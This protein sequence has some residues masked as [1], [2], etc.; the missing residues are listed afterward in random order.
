M[1][2]FNDFRIFVV[3]VCSWGALIALWI[4]GDAVL[5]FSQPK[6]PNWGGLAVAAI[7]ALLAIAWRPS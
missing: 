3:I 1:K 5:S 7:V 4:A 2:E 6:P